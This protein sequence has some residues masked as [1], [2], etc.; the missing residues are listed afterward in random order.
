MK[1]ASIRELFDYWNARRGRR[2][3]PERTEIEPGAIRRV[4]ADTFILAFEPGLGH[5]FRIAGT[6]V[7]ALFGREL[8][9]EGF[10]DLWA[11]TSRADLRDLAAI[12]ADESVG[13]V[14]SASG[15]SADGATLQLELLL[16][17][18]RHHG[19]TDARFLGALV[20][21]ER[22]AWLGTSALGNLTLGTHRY[23][24]ASVVPLPRP[25]P[26]SSAR[27]ALASEASGQRGNSIV[28]AHSVSGDARERA[29]VTRP[30]PGSSARAGRIQ[31][32]FIVYEGGQ[33]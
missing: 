24:G 25:E 13:V 29:G 22:P 33:S 14:A 3:A 17:P 12:V 18:L 19:R 9:G 2:P 21:C 31:H 11:I 32:G 5:P 4:L 1:H 6:R 15:A 27:A 8:K 23:V 28:R 26:G 20:P 7:C 10:L 30:E 16:L